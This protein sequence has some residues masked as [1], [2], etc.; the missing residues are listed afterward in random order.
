ML[1]AQGKDDD[2]IVEGLKVEV[3]VLKSRCDGYEKV[4]KD[5]TSRC[6]THEN[7]LEML[8]QQIV[9]CLHSQGTLS[10]MYHGKN[11]DI[12]P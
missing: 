7:A 9:H 12:M 6:D 8:R 3:Q 10:T 1:L 4:I 11:Y 5:L 2:G